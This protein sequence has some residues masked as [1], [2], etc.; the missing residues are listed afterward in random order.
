[1]LKRVVVIVIMGMLLSCKEHGEK[2]DEC[3]S[4]ISYFESDTIIVNDQM[5]RGSFPGNV[6][7]FDK[8]SLDFYNKEYKPIIKDPNFADHI[9]YAAT[10]TCNFH[11]DEYFGETKLHVLNSESPF[12]GIYSIKARKQRVKDSTLIKLIIYTDSIY[13][14]ALP[15]GWPLDTKEEIESHSN[16]LF[17]L[18]NE[19]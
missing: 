7:I 4:S 6:L 11:V 2:V 19:K 17:E 16:D 10:P 15:K 8:K 1:M 3:L 14:S 18:L 9:I 13:I 5:V 12:H